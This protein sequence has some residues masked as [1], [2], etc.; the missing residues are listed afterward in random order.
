LGARYP[1]AWFRQGSA[2]PVFAYQ[3][4]QEEQEADRGLGTNGGPY[5]MDMKRG[6]III[7]ALRGDFGK[8]RPAL[9]IRSDFFAEHPLVAVLP[10]TSDLEKAPLLRIPIDPTPQNG[11][12]KPS[13]VMIDAIQTVRREKIGKII[14]HI[15]DATM[16]AV[17]RLLTTFLGFA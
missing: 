3:E 11:L 17:T 15:D 5:R 2:A 8:P 12:R 16:L 10:I 14:G 1:P 4:I 7:I 9:V 6:D 13:H